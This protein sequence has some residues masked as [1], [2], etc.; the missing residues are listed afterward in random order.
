MTPALLEIGD[1]FQLPVGRGCT[2]LSPIDCDQF[3]I[4]TMLPLLVPH[5]KHLNG[6]RAKVD[7]CNDCNQRWIVNFADGK[8]GLIRNANL[9][10]APPSDNCN[11]LWIAMCNL[12]QVGDP[13][14]TDGD[15]PYCGATVGCR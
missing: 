12:C 8:V 2:K 5:D 1:L 11:F 14:P 13:T 6:L 10:I 9:S 15:C 4:S 3:V 7:Y